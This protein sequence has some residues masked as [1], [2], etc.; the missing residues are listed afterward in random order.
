LIK[1]DRVAKALRD[2]GDIEGMADA[3]KQALEGEDEDETEH[4][5]EELV[6]HLQ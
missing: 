3:I 4:R 1:R 5:I 2:L 6:S